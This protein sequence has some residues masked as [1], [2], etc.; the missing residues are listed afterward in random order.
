MKICIINSL[1]KPY[2]R[3]GVETV[4]E[5]IARGLSGQGDRVFIITLGFQD[6]AEEID[7]I[8][9]YRITSPNLFS[10]LNISKKFFLLRLFWHIIDTFNFMA[11]AKVR[12][13]I[14]E[15]KPGLVLTHNLKGLSYLIPRSIKKMNIKHIH[16]VHDVQLSVPTGLVLKGSEDL[17]LFVKL[18][19]AICKILFGSPEFII[20]PSRWIMDY[21]GQRGFFKDSK[22]ISLPNPI[23]M[24]DQIPSAPAADTLNF[25]FLGQVEEHKGIIFLVDAFKKLAK[26]RYQ[27]KIVGEGS[28][29]LKIG[30]IT[31]NFDNIHLAG[32]IAHEN[33]A[34]YFG[35][36]DFLIMP[37]ICY[38]N[39]PAVIFESLSAGVPVIAADIGGAVEIIKNGFN[40]YKFEAKNQE[41]FLKIINSVNKETA[42]RMKKQCRNTVFEYC[43]DNYI[44]RIIALE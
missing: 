35:W 40:G 29:V 6:L 22:K 24:F 1:Y 7:G 12:R 41:E 15:E 37:S 43:I 2:G 20:Y 5:S 14:A 32:K 31:K 21:Y 28:Q 36:A 27:L 9:I 16:T 3:G 42:Q 39:S 30:E 10:F 19:E 33:L 13:I 25:I 34:P 11:A 44:K 23:R 17:T 26:S 4:V 8:T 18:Y 38:E